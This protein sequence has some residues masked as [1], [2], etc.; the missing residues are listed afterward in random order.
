MSQAK[1]SEE[2][3]LLERFLLERR[4]ARLKSVAAHRC[5][6]LTIVL[7]QLHHPHNIS[8]V[9]RSADA[10]GLQTIHLVGNN[11]EI[12]SEITLGAERWLT[13]QQHDSAKKLIATLRQEGFRLVALQALSCNSTDV[14]SRSLPVTELPFGQK[15][16]LVF[17]NEKNGISSPFSEAADYFAYIPMFGFV[18]SLNVSVAAGICFFCASLFR[19]K[20]EGGLGVLSETEQS[21]LLTNWYK[22]DIRG[23]EIILQRMNE[24]NFL[25]GAEKSSVLISK[26][27]TNP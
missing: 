5:S 26:K 18:E 9:L 8:A 10:F 16:A 6:S 7:D 17:G 21:N 22:K 25:P 14:E 12:N 4:V 11:I 23:A 3:H 19:A 15:L 24:A 27:K 2:A 13:V 20:A 1:K